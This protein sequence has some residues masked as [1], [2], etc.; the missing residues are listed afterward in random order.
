MRVCNGY[1]PIFILS[2]NGV[3]STSKG[4]KVLA[5]RIGITSYGL[6]CSTTLIPDFPYGKVILRSSGMVSFYEHR[7]F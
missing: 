3:K 2:E 6:L 7:E 1:D 4:A 5:D